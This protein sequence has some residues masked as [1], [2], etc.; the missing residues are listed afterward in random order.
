VNNIADLS[1]LLVRIDKHAIL[2]YVYKL[3]KLVLL[4]TSN[5]KA[6]SALNFVKNSLRNIMGINT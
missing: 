3:L 2:S 1:V 6:F 5:E 4:T